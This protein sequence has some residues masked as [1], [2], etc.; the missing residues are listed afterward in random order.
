MT[1]PATF[2]PTGPLPSGRVA[3][4]AS[5]GT[6]KTWTI[7]A[8]T[9]RYVA[10]AAIPIDQILVV[11]FTRAAT[12]EL[13]GRVRARLTE[14]A[15]FLGSGASPDSNTDPILAHLVRADDAERRSR[16][17]RLQRAV[18]EFDR[19]TI[20]TLHGLAHRLLREVGL[21]AATP[22]DVTVGADRGNLVEE[23]VSDLVVRR[24]SAGAGPLP[25]MEDLRSITAATMAN[26]DGHIVPDPDDPD[27]HASERAD[28]ARNLRETVAMRAERAGIVS[29][30][31][32]LIRA[33]QALTDPDVGHLTRELTRDRFRVALV[34]EFQDTDRIQWDIVDTLMGNSG[35]LVVIGDPKQSIYA[36]RGA[37]VAAY[38]TAA[39]SSGA[40]H[41]LTTNWR[42]DEPLITA[43]DTLFDGVTFGD[44]RIPYRRVI[45]APGHNASR[46]RGIGAAVGVR[47]VGR[48]SPVRQNQNGSLSV[49]AAREFI[50]EDTAAYAVNLVSGQVEVAN[51]A[52]WRAVQP[53]DIAVLCRTGYEVGLVQAALA[54]RGIPAVVGRTGSVLLSDAAENW[55]SLLSAL[56]FPSSTRRVRA[57]ALSPFVGWTAARLLEA[58]DDDLLP[59]HDQVASWA[60]LLQTGSVPALWKAMEQD[61][62]VSESILGRPG[63]ERLATDLDHITEVLH[64]AHR[65]GARSLHDWLLAEKHRA[66]QLGDED[67][68]RARRLE[69]DAEAV[70]VLTIHGAKGL[71]FPIVLSPYLWHN[72]TRN[73]SIPVYHPPASSQR[74]I[75]VGGAG[76]EGFAEAQG[77]AQEE[78]SAEEARLMYVAMTRARHHVAVW[79]AACDSAKEA[80]LSRLLFGRDEGGISIKEA[81]ALVSNGRLASHIQK[82]IDRSGGTMGFTQLNT[83]AS[84]DI[85][86]ATDSPA[87]QL[88]SASF[89]RP[90]DMAWRRTSFS[91]ITAGA[92]H[93]SAAPDP[94]IEATTDEPEQVEE[95]IAEKGLPLGGFAG[96]TNFGTLVHDILEAVDFADENLNAAM[97]IACQAQIARRG[98]DLDQVQLADALTQAIQTPLFPEDAAPTLGDLQRTDRLAEMEFEMSVPAI[99]GAVPIGAIARVLRRYLTDG[100]PLRRY[101]DRLEEME[102]SDFSGYLSGAIDLVARIGQ[103][104]KYWV[105][106]YKTNRLDFPGKTGSIWNY[107]PDRMASAMINGDYVLQSILYQVALHR[108]LRFRID[109]YEIER[110]LGGSLY[111]F[112]RGMIGPHTPVT[113]A[114]RFGV[115]H[116]PANPALIK[117]LSHLFDNGFAA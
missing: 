84:M 81:I 3:L 76:W 70:Q 99:G 89:D 24:Y 92:Y 80:L 96:G 35:T 17:E 68:V 20:T 75:A 63:G 87:A 21:L 112:L 64:G 36:F 8:L 44:P 12:S 5:A 66:G 71:E 22:G 46:I 111:L 25:S 39:G 117:D 41:T 26:P 31:D 115:A 113:D 40:Q 7:A 65:S 51:G 72:P 67:D 106:D 14:A 107:A 18:A 101:A 79:W 50:A 56:E 49:P 19:A 91:G 43:L 109:D 23:V 54:A 98:L 90:I 60:K 102:A 57:V 2:A 78:S 16:A 85:W 104:P 27:R 45:P 55:L 33:R 4:E 53:G 88:S 94:G 30:D 6:G 13:R 105:I 34:D 95:L 74:M 48:S 69:T 29:F 100:H 110:N 114:G 32:V 83:S 52:T 1:P 58:T 116:W 61:N 73:Q 10:E 103:P 11:T 28:F 15:R 47:M 93:P 42:S 97:A 82:V 38:L 108:Y 59:L 62:R 86:T 37:D 9:T 77:I